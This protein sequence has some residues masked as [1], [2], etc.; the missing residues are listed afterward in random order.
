MYTADYRTINYSMYTAD[1][2]T[3]NYSMYTADY[4]S[5][6]YSLYL[7]FVFVNLFDLSGNALGLPLH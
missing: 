5:I 4:I 3:I 6:K 2:R 7:F 1:Y